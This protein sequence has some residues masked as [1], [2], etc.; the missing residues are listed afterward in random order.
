MPMTTHDNEGVRAHYAALAATY[1]AG[2][3]RACIAAYE[4]LARRALSGAV[5][6]LELGAGARP[7]SAAVPGARPVCV[8]LSPE[9]LAAG[10]ALGQLGHALVADGQR[11]PFADARF[12]AAV[13][14][15]VLE[16][17]P[18][19]AA[20]VAETARVLRPGGRVLMVTPNGDL[21][22]LLDLLETLHLKLPEGPHTFRTMAVTKTIFAAHFE[23]TEH[24]EFLAFPAGPPGLVNAVDRVLG[25]GLF[26][27]V[28]AVRR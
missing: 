1:D 15:N 8:D 20:F 27:Y 16:H 26:Q 19:P 28:V 5:D 9:M 21:E 22:W 6:V 12:D 7:V 2:A 10:R 14:I 24:C 11:L 25:R 17:V 13:S 4:V 3:N 23:I 18:D